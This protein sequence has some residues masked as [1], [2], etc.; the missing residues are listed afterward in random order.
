LSECGGGI[1]YSFVEDE[2]ESLVNRARLAYN[3][4]INLKGMI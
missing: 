4:A 2:P 3:G 1:L